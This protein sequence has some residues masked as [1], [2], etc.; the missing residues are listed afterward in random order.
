VLTSWQAKLG[1]ELVRVAIDRSAAVGG[2]TVLRPALPVV[3]WS[4]TP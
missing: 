1:G 4:V 3:L 2:F